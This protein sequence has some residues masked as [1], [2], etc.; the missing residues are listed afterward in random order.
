MQHK[1]V[2][3]RPVVNIQP[4]HSPWTLHRCS[5][6]QLG[7]MHPVAQ[8]SCSCWRFHTPL[9]VTASPFLPPPLWTIQTL[10]K[11]SAAHCCPLY[12]HKLAGI[13]TEGGGYFPTQRPVCIATLVVGHPNHFLL[14][15]PSRR[16][17]KQTSLVL[18]QWL[19][20]AAKAAG[21]LAIT[22]VY[23]RCNSTNMTNGIH[24][25]A[26]AAAAPTTSSIRT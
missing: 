17:C 19:P 9:Q 23:C 21:K 7:R 25:M 12:W 3:R 16:C 13:L 24:H 22:N 10:F 6:K 8:L 1:L 11:P 2:Q 20:R 4:E 15:S 26:R 18:A 5:M 14:P